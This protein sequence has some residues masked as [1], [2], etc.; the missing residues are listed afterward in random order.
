MEIQ[1]AIKHSPSGEKRSLIAVMA[2]RY[3]IEASKLLTTLKQTAFKIRGGQEVSNEQMIALLIVAN[4]YGLN[5]F[6][7]EIYAFPDKQG[8]I[9]PVVGVDGWNRIINSDKNFDGIEFTQ[10]KTMV[11]DPQGEHKECP[12]WMVAVIYRKDRSHPT[13][14]PEY[15]EETYRPPFRGEKNGHAYTINGPWQTHTKRMLRHKTEIQ[16]ARIAFGFVGIYDEDEAQRIIEHDTIDQSDRVD[17]KTQRINAALSQEVRDPADGDLEVL[18][19]KTAPAGDP[20]PAV[21]CDAS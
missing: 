1:P 13:S 10:S 17:E 14:I 9:V 8:G 16:C 19:E 7:R 15:F 21:D 4:Q 20:L 12:E 3:G 2:D 18:L 11:V 5:P 6:T